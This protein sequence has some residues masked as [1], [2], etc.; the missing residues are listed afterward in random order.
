[1]GN[2]RKI[3]TQ[4]F[5]QEAVSLADLIGLGKAAVDLGINPV[6]IRRWTAEAVPQKVE[7][8]IDLEKENRRLRKENMYL[9]KINEVLKKSTAIC[10]MD[11]MDSSK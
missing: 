4:E 7:N 1:M 11:H 9:K 6:N 8:S 2:K 3:Y 5:K 10:S